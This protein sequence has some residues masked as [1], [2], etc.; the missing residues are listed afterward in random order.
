MTDTYERDVRRPSQRLTILQGLRAEP[1]ERLNEH[2]L[3]RYLDLMG[4]RMARDD[5]RARLRELGDL[6]ALRIEMRGP[7]M[8]AELTQRGADHLE[9]RGAPLDGVER[10]RRA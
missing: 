5:V 4:H 10:P 9:R 3:S 7:V 6:D 8:V 2:D 1:D